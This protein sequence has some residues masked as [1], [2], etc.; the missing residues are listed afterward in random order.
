[1]IRMPKEE[2]NREED[3]QRTRDLATI[4]RDRSEIGK[5]QPRTCG[6]RDESRAR[7]DRKEVRL[8]A[9]GRTRLPARYRAR[10]RAREICAYTRSEMRLEAAAIGDRSACVT[11]SSLAIVTHTHREK[12]EIQ[13]AD[14]LLSPPPSRF[15]PSSLRPAAAICRSPKSWNLVEEMS[16]ILIVSKA[17]SLLRLIN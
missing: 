11:S 6:T 3:G 12:R 8:L 13:C 10:A 14:I 7:T 15:F 2:G 4:L 1:M 16:A 5:S 9:F 17:F